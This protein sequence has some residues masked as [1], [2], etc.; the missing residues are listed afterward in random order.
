MGDE[1]G[2]LSLCFYLTAALWAF[3]GCAPPFQKP[4]R[5]CRGADSVEDAL[6]VLEQRSRA[7]VS[8]RADGRCHLKYRAGGREH[9]ES[10]PVKLWVNPPAEIYLQGDVAFDPKGLVLGSNKKE[11]W[12]SLKPKEI[13]SY[14]WGRWDEQNCLQKLMIS[15]RLVLEALGAETVGDKESWLLSKE[16]AFDVLTKQEGAVET[17]K[18]YINTCDYLV[19]KIEYLNADGRPVVVVELDRYKQVSKDDFVPAAVK[20]TNFAADGSEDSARLSLDTIRPANF[21]EKQCNRLFTR[22]EQAGFEHIY[23]FGKNCDVYKEGTIGKR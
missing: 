14:W 9:N 23:K 3:A 4:V 10:I 13:S 2:N 11:F 12:L 1:R 6:S 19:R 15:P 7:A 16:G 18:I 22:P 17:E 20:I 21:T 5:I 8:F